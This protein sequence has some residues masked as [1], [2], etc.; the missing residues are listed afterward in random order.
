MK[1]RDILK[2]KNA[3][4]KPVF[5]LIDCAICSPVVLLRCSFRSLLCNT[6]CR[7]H[8]ACCK[9]LASYPYNHSVSVPN[10][11][12]PYRV[13]TTWTGV[14]LI[15]SSP[16]EQVSTLSCLHHVNRCLPYRVFTTWTGVHLIVSS[17]REQVSTLS[18]LH[19]VNRCLPYS[20]LT[21]WTGDHLIVSSP[22]EQVSTLSCPHHVSLIAYKTCELLE[23][24]LWNVS[25][26]AGDTRTPNCRRIQSF[27]SINIP[28][29]VHCWGT[30]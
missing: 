16:R 7:C 21:T 5:C 1:S 24:T 26:T 25:W 29:Q 19:H 11:C 14:H 28:W 6:Q 4:V 17:P 8:V 13:L 18:C 30:R 3:L 27:Y 9:V 22:R 12:P 20:V 2:V 15:V 23:T 10:R